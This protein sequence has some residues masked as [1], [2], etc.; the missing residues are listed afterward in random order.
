MLIFL[1][2][3]DT[4]R[5]RQQ[6]HKMTDKFKLDRDPQGLNLAKVDCEKTEPGS[7]FQQIFATP[8]LAERRMVVL[9][10]LFISKHKDLQEEILQRVINN[11]FPSTSVILFWEAGESFKTK[12]GKSLFTELVKEKF[13]QKFDLI[14]G[15]QLGAWASQL[16]KEKEGEISASAVQF[17]AQSVGGDMWRLS[18]LIDQLVSYKNKEK[19]ELAD[20][21]LFSDEKIDDNIFNLVDALIAKQGEKVYQMIQEQYRVGEDVQFLFAMIVRQFRILL[22]LRDL[23]E[24]NNNFSSDALAKQLGLHPFVVKKSLPMVKKY[25]L[26]DLKRI[27]QQLLQLDIDIKTGRGEQE[28]LLDVFV[29]RVCAR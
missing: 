25:K 17:L 27:Y 6:L 16:V 8:F 22:Q 9:E 28:V 13:C 26:E 21:Q 2:G 1:Y 23:Y 12:L 19:I 20:V 24:K 7:I 11:N 4:Y 5:S 29:G 18:S 15:A 14:T 10:N 3:K